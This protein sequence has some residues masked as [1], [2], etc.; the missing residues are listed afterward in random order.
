M[1]P[2]VFID[3]VSQ[4]AQ[5]LSGNIKFSGLVHRTAK[6]CTIIDY[7]IIKCF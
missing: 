4:N 5:V 3:G 6:V 7:S 2:A 1:I